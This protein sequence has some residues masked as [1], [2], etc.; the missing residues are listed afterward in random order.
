[1]SSK[2]LPNR[3]FY[4]FSKSI[5][6]PQEVLDNIGQAAIFKDPRHH[7]FYSFPGKY[8]VR[9]FVKFQNFFDTQTRVHTGS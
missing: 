8:F 1:M 4:N 2:N 5:S 9:A 3:F 7:Q 6:V